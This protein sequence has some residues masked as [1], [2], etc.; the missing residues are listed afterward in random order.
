MA[1]IDEL[2]D[3]PM[4]AGLDFN[5][6]LWTPNTRVTLCNVSFNSDYR[7]VMSPRTHSKVDEYLMNTEKT[8]MT[9]TNTTY[10]RQGEPIKL[11][12]PFTQAQK[13]NYIRVSNGSTPNDSG[14]TFYYFITD[15]VYVAGN[16][17]A[18]MVQLDIWTTYAHTMRLGNCYIERGHVGI[19]NSKQMDNNGREYLTTPEGLDIGG[20][21]AIAR[22]YQ[23]D[24]GATTQGNSVDVLVTST[25]SWEES[26]GT[27]DAPRIVAAKGS[28][29]EGMPN[30]A[31][32]YWFPD[33]DAW[34]QQLKYLSAVPWVAAGIISVMVVPSLGN[35][36]TERINVGFNGMVSHRIK[37]DKG[38]WATHELWSSDGWREALLNQFFPARYRSLKKFL[39]F[40]Y[41]MVE[42]TT[43][44]GTP[45]VLK[46]ESMHGTN[47]AVREMQHLSLPNPRVSFYP[48]K[49]NALK[50]D[51]PN[52]A[53]TGGYFADSGVND[54]A[55]FLDMTT[56][57]TNM[58]TFSV[59]NN[60]Y[61][62]FMANNANS[63]AYQH[64]S[65]DWSQQKALRSNTLTAAQASASN[66][67]GVSNAQA[68]MANQQYQT[69]L[70]NQSRAAQT[71]LGV[72]G[73]LA[74]GTMGGPSGL[75]AAA[76]SSVSQIG[77]AMI[78]TDVANRALAG[79]L[80]SQRAQ[81]QTNTGLSM[82]MRD[83]NK[84]YADYAA[85]G[86]YENTI[87][88]INAK[89]QD[90]K[91]IQPTTAGQ[92]GGD[93]FL[94]AV[95]KWEIA[96]KIK[97]LMPNQRAMLGEFWLRY[98]YAINRFYVPPTNLMVMSKFTYWKMKE[99]YIRSAAIPEAYK[100]A[101]RGILEKGVTVWEDPDDIG[102]I[103]IADNTA[104]G[105]IT[106]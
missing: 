33:I 66:A 72:G 8:V 85:N 43:H 69:D 23:N 59:L 105:G 15:V 49:Y 53:G 65:A 55:E 4:R 16:T 45:L 86:D 97:T 84:E 104:K 40:P 30:A 92:V 34:H 32:V 36:P 61:M 25:I 60:G 101:L 12:I 77:G 22:T 42:L 81:L 52:Q 95:H 64:A 9:L 67:A 57:I 62:Q 58:P 47:I 68:G 93:A 18:F 2:P 26:G 100:Q 79:N 11:D 14:V 3:S 96:A 99:V 94:L 76:L 103:D 80:A 74:G 6:S 89:I 19:A 78:S 102:M 50:F 29:F 28:D 98:G 41:T 31:E 35:P 1:T 106:L 88:G 90:A 75:G 38:A 13:F 71:A 91:M 83:S 39:T 46:P 87:A 82:Y 27:E 37:G 70:S 44:T 48:Y 24:I 7:D 63:L 56:G 20:E 21:Y 10:L 73:T 54:N 17:T 5:V 51:N